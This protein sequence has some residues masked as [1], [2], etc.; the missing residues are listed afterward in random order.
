MFAGKSVGFHM[1][2]AGGGTMVP[3]IHVADDVTLP[4]ENGPKWW[5]H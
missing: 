4:L 1:G 5:V 3:H 2:F